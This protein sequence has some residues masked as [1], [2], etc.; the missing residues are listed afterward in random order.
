LRR[1][2]LALMLPIVAYGVFTCGLLNPR[3][4]FA[5]GE[6]FE[7]FEDFRTYIEQTGDPNADRPSSTS[8]LYYGNKGTVRPA[9]D[10]Y[11]YEEG[12]DGSVT[13]RVPINESFFYSENQEVVTEIPAPE[14]GEDYFNWKYNN[15]YVIYDRS[16]GSEVARFAWNNPEVCAIRWDF[17][18]NTNGTPIEVFTLSDRYESER[19]YYAVL[20]G[21]TVLMVTEILAVLSV[22]ITKRR[23]IMKR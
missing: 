1:C 12:T 13:E 4:V 7:D 2:A 21:L 22:Y 3:T 15:E 16:D 5:E 14:E 11:G 8:M 10:A 23:K 17:R 18:E 6:M 20:S 9:R 19:I